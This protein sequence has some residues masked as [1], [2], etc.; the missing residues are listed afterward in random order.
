MSRASL[1]ALREVARRFVD[2][3]GSVLVCRHCGCVCGDAIWESSTD[4]DYKLFLDL[5]DQSCPVEDERERRAIQ[6]GE[7][8]EP[9]SLDDTLNKHEILTELARE[10]RE[11]DFK[12]FARSTGMRAEA[13]DLLWR[14]AR[15][16]L[17][18]G[19]PS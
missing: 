7:L 12:W 13:V 15:V 3:Y 10:G 4:L 1:S 16:A 5:V 18:D 19:S 8:S 14:T 9:R 6:A 11:E 17:R 2:E